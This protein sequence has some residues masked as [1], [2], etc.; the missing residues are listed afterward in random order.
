MIVAPPGQLKTTTVNTL[1]IYPDALC[2]SDINVKSLKSIRDQVLGGRYRT[3]AFG[4]FEKLY[5]RNPAT[6]INIEANLK[7]FIEEGLRHFSWE[8][9]ST[10]VMP[11]R[12]FVVAGL[13]PSMFGKYQGAWRESGFLR[14]FL[15]F[16]YVLDKE[17]VILD[18]VHAWIKIKVKMPLDVFNRKEFI[19]YNLSVEESK[20]IM[21][22]MED[23]PESTPTVLLKKITCVL[24]HY[25]P[26]EWRK[27][28]TDVAPSFGKDGAFLIL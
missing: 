11:A 9:S 15:K 10:T 2:I 7:Q 26:K 22:I 5:S 13:T 12:A 6:A 23:A 17:G 21:K 18:A 28:I 27:I 16:Q 19:K 3:L 4:E 8:D 14:R 1:D 20:F 25:Q 24:K